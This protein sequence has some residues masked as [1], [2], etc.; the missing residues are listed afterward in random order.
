[1]SRYILSVPPAYYQTGYT[2]WA[3]GAASWLHATRMGLATPE[4][5]IIRFGS[6]LDEDGAI[7]ES[8]MRN[9]FRQMKIDLYLNSTKDFTYSFIRGYLE[10][11]GHLLLMYAATGD[12]LAHT[13]VIY[14][15][16]WPSD[17]YFNTFDSLKGSGGY[18]SRAFSAVQRT[19]SVF[20]I[21]WNAMAA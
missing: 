12:D 11:K 5:L 10:R 8:D 14:G 2:C 1:M 7:A 9:I 15:V 21:G 6:Y 13:Y 20:Y 3:A 4:Q 17:A 18:K 16:G 19:A